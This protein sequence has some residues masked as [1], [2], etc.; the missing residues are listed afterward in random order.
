MSK[1]KYEKR[2]LNR[3]TKREEVFQCPDEALDTGF[4]KLH[5]SSYFEG[6]AKDVAKI[7]L[8]KVEKAVTDKTTLFAIGYNLPSLNI[9]SKRFLSPVYFND[10]KFYGS[11]QFE[12]NK[13]VSDAN[14][15]NVEFIND[16]S[17]VGSEFN[18]LAIFT[19]CKFKKEAL[20]LSVEFKKYTTFRQVEFEDVSFSLSEFHEVDFLLTKFQKKSEFKYV[21][22]YANVLFQNSEFDF[23]D[24]TESSFR[25]EGIFIENQFNN[26]VNFRRIKFSNPELILFDTNMSKISFLGTDISKIT[27]GDDTNWER[28]FDEPTNL[29][30]KLSIGF[31]KLKERTNKFKTQ[32]ERI[33]ENGLEKNIHL[34]TVMNVYRNLRENFDKKLKYDFAG[35]FFVRE[36]ELKRKYKKNSHKSNEFATTH[37]HILLRIFSV[38]AFYYIIGKYGESYYRPLKLIIPGLIFS[39]LYFGS[40]GF[41]DMSLI[42]QNGLGS[43]VMNDTIIRSISAFFPFYVFSSHNALSDLL[44]R[45]AL[46]PMLGALFIALKRKLE[47]RYYHN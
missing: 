9:S 46:L 22:F 35:E 42:L 15:E 14:F 32:D 40:L 36:M 23:V 21:K 31:D 7:F 38:L 26:Q 24:F 13:F 29:R 34:E 45:I 6:N 41:S 19:E 39:A 20:F 5:D 1:C 12:S 47:R 16:V 4:C 2:F 44:L 30:D 17:F 28:E 25:K 11:I 18:E 37:K 43:S 27:F 3:S 33:I 8:E 10:T